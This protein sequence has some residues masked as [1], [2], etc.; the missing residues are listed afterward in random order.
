MCGL[1]KPSTEA[2]FQRRTSPTAER[3]QAFLVR[4]PTLTPPAI[5]TIKFWPGFTLESSF[6]DYLLR[7]AFGSYALAP[8][9]QSADIVMSSVFDATWPRHP[10]RTICFIGENVRPNYDLCA[11]SI[12]SDFDNYSGRNFRLP[13][14]Y[15]QLQW[16]GFRVDGSAPVPTNHAFEN[17][18]DIDTLLRPRPPRVLKDSDL[19]CCFVASSYEQHR[20]LC[21]DRLMTKGHVD[22]FGNIGKPLQMSK[23]NILPRY[24][25]NLCFENSSFPG[26]YTEK[27]LQAW[28]GGCVPL[29][30]SDRWY[31]ADFNPKA[32]INRIDFHTIDEFV[33][34]VA[35]INSSP[36]AYSALFEQPLLTRRPTLEPAIDFLKKAGKQIMESRRQRSVDISNVASGWRNTSRNALCPC[37]SGKRYK[38]C[39]GVLS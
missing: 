12:S 19:F 22:V 24:R 32:L 26:Y 25:F 28:V 27:A 3:P 31:D 13:L 17:P 10:E 35:K 23:Y 7:Q 9:E 16:P 8:N 4:F 15:G 36:S 30:F 34:H 29:Y 20:M 14:W 1:Y 37:G 11:Y 2:S 18:V 21:L 5:F 6:L 39:H 33:D 38:R